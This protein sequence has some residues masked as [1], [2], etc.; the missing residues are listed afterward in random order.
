MEN[1]DEKRM[2]EEGN[3]RNGFGFNIKYSPTYEERE[4]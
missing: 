2:S 1:L 4:R 3:G